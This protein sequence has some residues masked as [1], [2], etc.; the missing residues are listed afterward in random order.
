MNKVAKNAA[1][2]IA[3][4]IIQSVLT[5][6]IGMLTARYLG[7]SNYGLIN[8]AV[9]LVAFV[10]PIMNLGFGNVLVK[11]L[12]DRPEKEGETLGTAIQTS[13]ISSLCCIAG[14]TGFAA[15]ANGGDRT[16]VLVCFLYSLNLI[17][18]AMELILYWYQS[19]LLSKFTSIIGLAAYVVTAAYRIF[20]LVSG[21]D[22]IWFALSN[23]IDYGIIGI[24]ALIVY[25]KLGGSKFSF[26]K[27]ALSRMFSSSKHYILSSM[28]ITVFAQTDKI[29]IKHMMDDASVGYYGAAVTCAGVASF[30][31]TALIDSFRPSVLECPPDSPEFENRLATLYSVVIYLSLAQS[32]VMTIFPTLIVRVLYGAA[33]A[34]AAPAL[35]I[36]VWYTTFSYLGAVRGIWMLST[37]NQKHLWKIN[38]SGAL[39]NVALNAV[40]IPFFGIYGAAAASLVTQIF[41]NVVTGYII[42]PVRPNNAIM[43]KG[44]NPKYLVSA[45]R[46]VFSRKGSAP[47]DVDTGTPE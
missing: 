36:I 17:F 38:L 29:M 9:S 42:K 44:L 31:F 33:Y 41:T 10:V 4:K 5:F 23:V 6:V 3:C 35:A 39:A 20:L 15:V 13:F 47:T 46:K 27:P 8:Y 21:S 28:M 1:W 30:V 2:I 37:N 11:E 34:P 14:V 19:K 25:K 12:I 16:T 43:V 26:S 18:Q 7:P 40:L 45:F 24:A 22:I 32:L